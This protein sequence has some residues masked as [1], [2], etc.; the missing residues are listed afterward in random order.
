MAVRS[1]NIGD[2][3]QGEADLNKKQHC[4]IGKKKYIKKYFFIFDLIMIY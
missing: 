3:I 2:L 4:T 1:F